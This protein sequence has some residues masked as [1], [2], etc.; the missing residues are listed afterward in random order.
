M[1]VWAQQVPEEFREEA[2]KTWQSN[3]EANKKPATIT[4]ESKRKDVTVDMSYGG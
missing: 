4:L 1:K 3:V 2:V